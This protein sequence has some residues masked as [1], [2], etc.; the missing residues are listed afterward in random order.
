MRN[1]CMCLRKRSGS[2]LYLVEKAP[3]IIR[4]PKLCLFN[5]KEDG[6]GQGRQSRGMM[7][8]Q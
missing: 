8:G 3:N 1:S 5:L 4:H 2:K 6:E 7:E